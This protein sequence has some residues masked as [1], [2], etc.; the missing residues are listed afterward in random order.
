MGPTVRGM[1][2]STLVAATL[3]L[4]AAA[5]ASAYS[6]P[7][8]VPSAHAGSSPLATLVAAGAPKRTTHTCQATRS[9]NQTV[10][11]GKFIPVACEQPPRVNMLGGSTLSNALTVDSLG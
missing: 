11:R 6:T 8:W 5:A 4:A 1:L 3:A 9:T 7:S 2:A 10:R